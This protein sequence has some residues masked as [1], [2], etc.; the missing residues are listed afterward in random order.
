MKFLS[1]LNRLFLADVHKGWLFVVKHKKAEETAA[2]AGA[3]DVIYAVLKRAG[4]IGA[5]IAAAATFHA[6]TAGPIHIA[7]GRSFENYVYQV[8]PRYHVD[9]AAE[10]AISTQEGA[11]GGIGDNGTSFGPNQLH[12]GGALPMSVYYGPYSERT[13]SWA[14]SSTGINYVLHQEEELCGGLTGYAAVKCI[15]YR[16]ERSIN[17]A[18]ETAGAWANYHYFHGP[19]PVHHRRHLTKAQ[20]LRRRHQGFHS[21]LDWSLAVGPWKGYHKF[22]QHVRPHVRH[23]APRR[24]WKARA[25]YLRSHPHAR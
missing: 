11:G 22:D 17:P 4:L 16:F 14:W 10:L 23:P 15:A 20:K 7:P 13:Q 18:R 3:I 6:A 9:P 12:A 19:V 24:W 5:G 25:R 8:A 2:E 1:D 21:W